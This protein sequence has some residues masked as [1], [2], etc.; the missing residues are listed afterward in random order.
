[1][2]YDR[3]VQELPEHFEDNITIYM[4]HFLTLLS[5]DNLNLHSKNNDPGILDQ[6]KTEICRAVALY[7]DNY[8][9][10]FKPYAQEFALAI[11][12]LLTRLNLSSSYDELISTAMKFLSTLA[13][14]SH[15][16]S[17]F[18]GDDTLKIVCEQVILP[19]LFLRETDV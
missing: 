8:S 5:Y 10:E 7:A 2:F 4:T 12:S 16:C 3:N 6:V 15:H 18:V 1:M 11:W 19:N 13:A 9:D 17:M 14:R